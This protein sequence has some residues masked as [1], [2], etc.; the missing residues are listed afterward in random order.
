M[1]AK[2]DGLRGNVTK[3][4]LDEGIVWHLQKTKVTVRRIGERTGSQSGAFKN[5]QQQIPDEERTMSMA[6]PMFPARIGPASHMPVPVDLVQRLASFNPG[7]PWG[8]RRPYRRRDQASEPAL[9]LYGMRA[10][11]ADACR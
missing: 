3:D 4:R 10:K 9:R 7:P 6:Y 2:T 11:P 5:H 8:V 1:I